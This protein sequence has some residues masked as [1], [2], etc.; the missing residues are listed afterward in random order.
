MFFYYFLLVIGFLQVTMARQKIC[1]LNELEELSC[2]EFI[3]PN[4]AKQDAFL[5]FFKQHCYAYENSCPHTG[6]NLNW[7]QEQF[8]S[9]DGLYLQCSLHGAL[10]EPDSGLCIRGPCVGAKLK[11]IDLELSHDTVYCADKSKNDTL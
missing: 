1:D 3:V 5:V 9:Y 4:A 7:Q 11:K 6:V 8:F 2:K 10:I